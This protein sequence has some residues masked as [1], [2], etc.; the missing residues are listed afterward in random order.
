MAPAY[1]ALSRTARQ[2]PALRQPGTHRSPAVAHTTPPS[3]RFRVARAAA[4][5]PAKPMVVTNGE[6]SLGIASELRRDRFRRS[7][8]RPSRPDTNR[9]RRSFGPVG[10][11]LAAICVQS[12]STKLSRLGTEVP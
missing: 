12:S 1:A 4:N 3:G 8:Q 9:P 6:G 7:Y 10:R 11:F 2:G 5:P